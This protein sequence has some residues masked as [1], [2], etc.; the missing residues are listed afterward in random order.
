MRVLFTTQPG[1]GMFNP[2]VPFARALSM[3]R[4]TVA[5][6]C[7]DCFRPE[8]EAVGLRRSPRGST[9]APKR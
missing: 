3:A 4:H 8:I 7:A 1:S 9:G 5:F 6:A 2:L